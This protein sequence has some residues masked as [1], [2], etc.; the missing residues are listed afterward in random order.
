MSLLVYFNHFETVSI[1][2]YFF[3]PFQRKVDNH[4]CIL[5]FTPYSYLLSSYCTLTAFTLS[6]NAQEHAYVWFNIFI[7]G[8]ELPFTTVQHS[9]PTDGSKIGL[10][11]S[12]GEDGTATHTHTDAESAFSVSDYI[13]DPPSGSDCLKRR[14]SKQMKMRERKVIARD[15]PIWYPIHILALDPLRSCIYSCILS[16]SHTKLFLILFRLLTRTSSST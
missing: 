15:L 11:L 10:F 8:T 2:T 7:Y 14:V 1:F 16:D 5:R 12:W 3:N 4:I 9:C 6:N 13:K